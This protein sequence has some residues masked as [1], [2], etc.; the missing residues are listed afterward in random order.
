MSLSGGSGSD[1]VVDSQ[2]VNIPAVNITSPTFTGAVTAGDVTATGSVTAGA[3]SASG[4][5]TQNGDVSSSGAISA[6]GD[7]T[8]SNVTANVSNVS[9]GSGNSIT[10]GT[11][12]GDLTGTADKA[13]ELLNSRTIA[14]QSF[15]GTQDV[16]IAAANLTDVSD[17]GSGIIMS[18]AERLK[19][20]GVEASA[21]VTDATNVLVAGA[22]MT[23]GVQSVGGAKTFTSDVVAT[24]DVQ[25]ATF[26]GALV[27]NASSATTSD[28]TKYVQNETGNG[29]YPVSFITDDDVANTPYQNS[30]IDPQFTYNPRKGELVLTGDGASVPVE[31]PGV[32]IKE[33][34]HDTQVQLLVDVGT[35]ESHA[36]L[37][38]SGIMDSS[39][40]T[41]LEP[42]MIITT[43]N[44]VKIGTSANAVSLLKNSDAYYY[45]YT[46]YQ[47]SMFYSTSSADPKFVPFFSPG[48]QSSP[49]F[50]TTLLLGENTFV[51]KI[52]VSLSAAKTFEGKLGFI[53]A[54]TAP[55]SG[56][57]ST[58]YSISSTSATAYQ[59][60]TFDTSA[61]GVQT[62]GKRL[63]MW[64]ELGS[65]GGTN[66]Q[67][68][69]TLQ[70][71]KST[72]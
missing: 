44:Q 54:G 45:E 20:E 52:V 60:Y 34:L 51:R 39:L 27:G 5:I 62:A 22:V 25:A 33:Q 46:T 69:W 29:A 64:L 3:V 9:L 28:T 47:E 15:N 40:G 10:A 66:V 23:T 16:S 37:F 48:E 53:P 13:V 49:N 72:Y 41:E 11:F 35:G 12:I 4:A 30:K 18:D 6:T 70:A 1:I 36:E 14:D 71:K 65:T 59:S 56:S 19:L 7:V 26:T 21:D 68:V 31:Y 67:V 63:G 8:V 38:T 2:T 24:G 55:S 50:S 32:I 17:A 58:L 42:K 57:F 43:N 61:V